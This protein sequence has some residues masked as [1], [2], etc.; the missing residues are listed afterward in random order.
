MKRIIIFLS[1]VLVLSSCRVSKITEIQVV[2]LAETTKS[3]NG[4]KL[5]NYPEGNPKITVL[6]ITIPPKT[7]LHKHYH[8]VINSGI[9]LKGELT[10][11]DID[12]NVLELKEGDV[13][14]EL[15]NKVHYGINK[16]NKPAE[17]IV[18][19]SGTE[20]LPITVIEKD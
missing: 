11:V 17:I 7:K 6:K 14:V 18:F 4:D 12:N 2:K 5:P 8:P 10:V 13:I 20:D 9:L 1:F 3:W 19:Y 16:S 15:V